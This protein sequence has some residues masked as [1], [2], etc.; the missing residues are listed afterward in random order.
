M[1][2]EHLSLRA[3]KRLRRS[4][5][6]TWE[7]VTSVRDRLTPYRAVC[8]HLQPRPAQDVGVR[9]AAV[10]PLTSVLQLQGRI[11]HAQGCPP[12][13]C[14]QGDTRAVV[15]FDG[16]TMWKCS[17]TRCDV[18]LV[19]QAGVR[20]VRQPKSWSTWWLLDG[21]DRHGALQALDGQFGLSQ[22][23]CHH[24]MHLLASTAGSEEQCAGPWALWCL[25]GKGQPDWFPLQVDAVHR[26]MR[27]PIG[28]SHT[29]G[30]RCLLT[31]D[32]KAMLA[33]N[34]APGHACW[35][36]NEPRALWAS[37]LEPSGNLTHGLRYG[38]F[39]R[40]IPSTL[41][42]SWVYHQGLSQWKGCTANFAGY[43]A[44]SGMSANF[45][46]KE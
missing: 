12:Q 27:N 45:W 9:T 28:G 39:L 5:D 31:G 4:P 46:T 35:V 8:K 41:G 44:V 18:A 21:A 42:L 7:A 22:Q 24:S 1:R 14:A 10:A 6:V 30:V 33:A 38:A 13:V 29:S 19:G 3:L 17:T 25:N 23:V 11:M 16:T 15:C 34:F 36:C 32:G 20:H 37:Q 26:E 40:S 43:S 2:R